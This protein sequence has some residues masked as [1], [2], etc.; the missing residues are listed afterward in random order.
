MNARWM[1]KC[2]QEQV[3]EE[4]QDIERARTPDTGLRFRYTPPALFGLGNWGIGGED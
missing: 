1:S 3:K 4:E 2:K